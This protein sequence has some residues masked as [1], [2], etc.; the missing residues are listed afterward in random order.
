[1]ADDHPNGWGRRADPKGCGVTPA[2][3]YDR[4]VTTQEH[5]DNDH[6]RTPAN[7]FEGRIEVDERLQ[8]IIDD[9]VESG[10]GERPAEL[11][12]RLAAAIHAAGLPDMPPN[13]LAAVAD[14]AAAGN[15]YVVSPETTR[16]EPVPPPANGEPEPTA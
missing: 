15:P 1:M 7:S 4:A 16:Y 14:S 13:W 6:D 5:G 8:Q 3:A 11:I 12:S 2:A 10:T 9:L